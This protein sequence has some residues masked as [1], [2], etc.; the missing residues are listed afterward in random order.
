MSAAFNK[1]KQAARLNITAEFSGSLSSGSSITETA[2]LNGDPLDIFSNGLSAAGSPVS[3]KAA[4]TVAGTSGL[5]TGLYDVTV[6]GYVFKRASYF[7]GTLL[8]RLI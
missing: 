5:S 2:G 4:R 3:V 8:S 7:N 1:M 6:Y